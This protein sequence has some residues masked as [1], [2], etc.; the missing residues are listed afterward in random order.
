MSKRL[1]GRPI[2]DDV[3]RCRS[4]VVQQH[5]EQLNGKFIIDSVGEFSTTSEHTHS[6]QY[7]GRGP[8]VKRMAFEVWR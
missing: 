5:G 1:K 4:A 3:V 2:G 7:M 8:K 6:I